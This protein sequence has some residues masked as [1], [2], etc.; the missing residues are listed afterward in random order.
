LALVTLADIFFL[1]SAKKVMEG[2]AAKAQH[3]LKLGMAVALAAFLAVA[4]NK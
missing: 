3:D 4:L 2:D 1:L